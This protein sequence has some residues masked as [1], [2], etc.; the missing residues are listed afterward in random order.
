MIPLAQRVVAAAAAACLAAAPPVPAVAQDDVPFVTTPDHVTLAM[1]E[2][3]GVTAQDHVVDLGSGDGRI[4]I[5]AARRFGATALGVEIVGD[6]VRQSR[7]SARRAG[8]DDR[9][10]FVEQD[11]F[12]TDLRGASVVTLYLLQ[13]VNLQLRP[14]L[15]QLAPGTRIVSHDWDLGDWAPERTLVIDVPDKAVGRD[16]RSRLHLWT[17]PARVHG[18]WCAAAGSLQVTQRF[19]AFSATLTRS[20][21]SAPLVVFD[22]LVHGD[23]LRAHGD[24]AALTASG[25]TLTLDR[26]ASLGWPVTP[27]AFGRAAGERCR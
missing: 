25:E 20:G 12:A 19:A 1:L 5:T 10:R 22:G 24:T 13:A 11:L 26:I 6:L 16:K 21:E 17:V 23:A 14:R 27:L 7:A 15:L 4:V 9:V 18:L 8:V 2:L 3:A